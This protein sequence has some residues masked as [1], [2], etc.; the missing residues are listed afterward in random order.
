MDFILSV[1]NAKLS[2][3]NL[4]GYLITGNLR[5]LSLRVSYGK[6]ILI[7]KNMLLTLTINN[8]DNYDNLL[9]QREYMDLTQKKDNNTIVES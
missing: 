9:V 6:N 2:L 1:K 7:I 5:D 8:K 3:V 4:K